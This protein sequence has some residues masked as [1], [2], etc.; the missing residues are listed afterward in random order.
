[1]AVAWLLHLP[2]R[3]LDDPLLENAISLMTPF[4]AYLAAEGAHASG[5]LAVVVAG[6]WMGHRAPV[7]VSGATRLQTRAVWRLTDFLLE[8]FVFLLI[9][10]QLPDVVRGLKVYPAHEVVGASVASVLIV[11][12]IRPSGCWSPATCQR[13]SDSARRCRCRRWPR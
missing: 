11:L 8:G 3:V 1:M 2:R 13:G 7:V 12:A 10:Q 6:L 9:G 4:A 5:V